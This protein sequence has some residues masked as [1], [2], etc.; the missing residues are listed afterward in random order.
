MAPATSPLLNLINIL[1]GLF[2]IVSPLCISYPETSILLISSMTFETIF[3]EDCLV[4]LSLLNLVV[5][6]KKPNP[7]STLFS[8]STPYR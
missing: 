6:G 4:I 2:T 1:S 3:P 8:P 7:L 5:V